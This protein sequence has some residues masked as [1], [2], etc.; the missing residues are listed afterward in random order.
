MLLE[1]TEKEIITTVDAK[2][3]ISGVALGVLITKGTHDGFQVILD[4]LVR[5]RELVEFEFTLPTSDYRVRS[6]YFPKGTKFGFPKSRHA[7]RW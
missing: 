3:G 5:R 6:L 1:E 2:P 7:H 4:D